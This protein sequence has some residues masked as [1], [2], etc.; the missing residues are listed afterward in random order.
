MRQWFGVGKLDRAGMRFTPFQVRVLAGPGG[1]QR[2]H[3]N[4]D[5]TSLVS[6]SDPLLSRIRF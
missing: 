4:K 2:M 1:G 3:I 5:L 6:V